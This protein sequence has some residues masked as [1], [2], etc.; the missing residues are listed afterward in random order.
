MLGMFVSEYPKPEGYDVAEGNEGR[1]AGKAISRI[2]PHRG[3]YMPETELSARNSKDLMSFL[4]EHWEE[5]CAHYETEIA[6]GKRYYEEILAGGEE[7]AG[8]QYCEVISGNGE[9]P[10]EKRHCEEI[11]SFAGA[12]YAHAYDKGVSVISF[13][14]D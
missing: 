10:T 3:K 11:L 9:E 13:C 2:I 7:P 1:T 4:D 12:G 5:V 8:K 6:A 14:I